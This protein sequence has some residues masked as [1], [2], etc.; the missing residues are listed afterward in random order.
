[1]SREGVE[2]KNRGDAFMVQRQTDGDGDTEI[3]R[4]WTMENAEG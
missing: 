4:N 1:L 2:M 3:N